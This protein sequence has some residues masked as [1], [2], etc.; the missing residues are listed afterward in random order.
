MLC[1]IV[2]GVGFFGKSHQGWSAAVI[3]Q[4]S[5]ALNLLSLHGLDVSAVLLV[6]TFHVESFLRRNLRAGVE[7]TGKSG[8]HLPG[9][10]QLKMHATAGAAGGS[11]SSG[12]HQ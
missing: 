6:A 8:S 3:R 9:M 10:V 4:S 5:G 12:H 7:V 2:L 11:G 1:A